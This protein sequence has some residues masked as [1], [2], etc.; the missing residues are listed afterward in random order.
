MTAGP[1]TLRA[2][3]PLVPPVRTSAVSVAVAVAVVVAVA[4]VVVWD[5]GRGKHTGKGAD[6]SPAG[7]ATLGAALG[8]LEAGGTL[9]G[10]QH[11]AVN[12][13]HLAR[14]LGVL[15]A[16]REDGHLGRSLRTVTY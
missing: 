12:R 4:A 5:G 9:A 10:G 1:H 3:C 2:T 7:E 16:D 15:K 8:A 11:L 14:V 6:G 13:A